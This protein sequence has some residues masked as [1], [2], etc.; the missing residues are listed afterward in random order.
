MKFIGLMFLSLFLSGCMGSGE[1]SSLLITDKHRFPEVK[2]IDLVGKAQWL[3]FAFEGDV[4]LVAIGF[5]REHQ[6]VIDQYYE[7]LANLINKDERLRF[8]EVPVIYEMGTLSRWWLNN[9]MRM[10]VVDHDA[11]LRTIT[12]Y[13]DR[14]EFASHFDM[15][16]KSPYLLVLNKKDQVIWK[17]EGALDGLQL[18]KV[19]GVIKRALVGKND[20]RR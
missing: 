8:Y 19:R 3:P 14:S 16:L 6:V 13:T 15:S 18:M 17:S 7:Q 2:G 9:A 12:V 10:G 11:R 20:Q 4:N 1:I 5:E